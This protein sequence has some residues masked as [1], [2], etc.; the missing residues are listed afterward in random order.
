MTYTLKRVQNYEWWITVV[1]IDIIHL[2]M[3]SREE[4]NLIPM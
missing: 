1:N 4:G 2:M 3:I